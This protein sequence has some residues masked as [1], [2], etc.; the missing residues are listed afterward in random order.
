MTPTLQQAIT[1]WTHVAPVLAPPRSASAYRRMVAALDAVL[2]AGG[3]DESH[4]LA[5]MADYMGE[6]IRAYEDTHH[7]RAEMPVGAFLR[8]LLKREGLRQSEVPEIGTQGMVSDV[9]RGRRQLT[10]RQIAALAKRF[11]IPADVLLA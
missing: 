3:A 2:D 1:H 11:S 10:A 5:S 4:P 6:L 7:P 9:L 8:E